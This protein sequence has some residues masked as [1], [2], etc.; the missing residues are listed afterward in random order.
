MNETLAQQIEPER[1]SG[2]ELEQSQQPMLRMIRELIGVTPSCDPILDI[3]PPGFRTF[4]VLVPSLLNLPGAML[5]Q[6]PAKELVGIALYTSSRAS[7]CPYCTAHHC[8]FAIRRGANPQAMLGRG[9]GV[10]AAVADLAEAMAMVPPMV[11][12]AHV[13]AVEQHLSAEELEWIVLAV[14]LGGFLN[15]F[16]DNMGIELE[17]RTIADV[18][19]LLRPTGWKPGKHVRSPYGVEPSVHSAASAA[20]RLA[21]PP[22]PPEPTWAAT[23]TSGDIPLDGFGSYLRVLRQAPSAVR[24]EKSWTKGVSGRIGPALLMLEE[25][26]GYGFPVLAMLRSQ[27]AVKALATAIRDNLDPD[28]TRVGIEAKLLAGLVY[29][30]HVQA[31]VLADELIYL[32]D[33]LVPDADPRLVVATRRFAAAPTAVSEFPQ[34]LTTEQ[35]AALLLAKAAAPSPSQVSE[36]TVATVGP[37]LQADEIVELMVWLGLLQ[38]LARLYAFFDA[39]MPAVDADPGTS[40]LGR[41]AVAGG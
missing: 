21:L 14:G 6:G 3:W 8:S 29:A 28:T 27:K 36:I 24:S 30:G 26:V 31:H 20:H 13:R 9:V 41:T 39:A 12:E 37:H 11:S 38:T 35:A 25:Q 4:N 1:V 33:R 10:E 7:G 32:I 40:G 23:D 17:A 15:K 34:G 16:M 22:L 2:D 19:A 5:G 18:Q